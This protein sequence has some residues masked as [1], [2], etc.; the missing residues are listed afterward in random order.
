[1]EKYIPTSVVRKIIADILIE[2]GNKILEDADR[3]GVEEIKRYGVASSEYQ[4]ELE[5]ES[6]GT[7]A[8]ADDVLS[9][10]ISLKEAIAEVLNK[11][12]VDL[13]RRRC[14]EWLNEQ[15]DFNR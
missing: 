11:Y 8:L 7:Y 14:E 6:A 10:G 9:G 3:L 4:G 13:A 2:R 1:M 12:E 15:K 5:T